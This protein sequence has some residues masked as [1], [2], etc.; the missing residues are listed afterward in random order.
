[1]RGWI[2]I[3]G[4]TVLL[5]AASAQSPSDPLLKQPQPDADRKSSGCLSC[6]SPLETPSMHQTNTVR[7]GCTD[8]HGGNAE[9]RISTGTAA[10]SAEYRQIKNQ[11]HPKSRFSSGSESSANPERS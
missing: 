6:H 10:N 5:T 9:V 3:V 8:C 4:M 2:S 7:L 11:A 1:M